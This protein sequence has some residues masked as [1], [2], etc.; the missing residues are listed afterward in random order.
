MT[1]IVKKFN[2]TT[3][4]IT[5][6]KPNELFTYAGKLLASGSGIE[7]TLAGTDISKNNT[8][9]WFLTLYFSPGPT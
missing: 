4:Q 7:Y 1:P 5:G 8:G 2:S 9:A 6:G 3:W